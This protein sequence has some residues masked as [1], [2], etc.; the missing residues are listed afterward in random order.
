MIVLNFYQKY[1]SVIKLK[2][3]SKFLQ[4]IEK[5]ISILLSFRLI[6]YIIKNTKPVEVNPDTASKYEFKYVIFLIPK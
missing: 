4:S 6:V 1:Q 5:L 2:I 3:E